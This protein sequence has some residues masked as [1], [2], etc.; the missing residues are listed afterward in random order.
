M[1]AFTESQITRLLKQQRLQIEIRLL[2][3]K[4]R[5]ILSESDS[6]CRWP[7]QTCAGAV[8]QNKLPAKNGQL[9]D[10]SQGTQRHSLS[11]WRKASA[12]AGLSPAGSENLSGSVFTAT[13]PRI[14]EIK[15]SK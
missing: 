2:L 4:A 13:G 12:N 7:A 8:V 6:E 1:S 15:G 11:D 14:L 3:W 10:A 9:R 5:Q